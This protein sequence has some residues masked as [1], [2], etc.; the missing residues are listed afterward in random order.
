VVKSYKVLPVNRYSQS[1]AYSPDG[2]RIAVG[3]I[4]GMVRIW[5]AAS[6]KQL[7]SFKAHSTLIWTVAYSPDGQRILTGSWDH[8]AKVWDPTS[9]KELL[10][11]KGHS[12]AVFTASFS[13]NGQR[14]VTGGW[15]HS[16][17]VW[18]A[19]TAQQIDVWREEENE[20]KERLTVRQR[21]HAGPIGY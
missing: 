3:D 10:T 13:P 7:F 19:A 5:D 1:V 12:N 9:G 18:D 20:N 2:H 4:G 6:Y 11:L 8:T 16:A 15:D 17:R 21:G 14:I